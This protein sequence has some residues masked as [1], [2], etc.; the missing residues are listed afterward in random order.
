MKRMNVENLQKFKE[1][2]TRDVRLPDGSTR[3]VRLTPDFWVWK[4]CVQEA[5]CVTEEELSAFALEEQ[6]LQGFSFDTAY[7][8]VVA[9]LANR[10]Q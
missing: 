4:E 10:W 7:R 6:Q 1:E 3:P 8:C 5:D 9:Y 2:N